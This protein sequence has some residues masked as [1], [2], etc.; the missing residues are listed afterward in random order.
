MRATWLRASSAWRRWHGSRRGR[1]A[2][3]AEAI[4]SRR[5]HRLLSRFIALDVL[6]H[7]YI[8]VRLLPDASLPP[9]VAWAGA[10]LLL[11]SCVAIPLG[12]RNRDS[13]DPEHGDFLAWAGA[14]AMGLLS[15]LFV[16]TLLRDVAF[17]TA[18]LAG[19]AGA[20]VPW[21][22]LRTASAWGVVLLALAACGA[23]FFNARRRARVVEVEVPVAGLPAA[24]EGFT[25]VQLSDIHVGPTIKRGYVQA[26]VDAVNAA[27]A[28]MVAITGDVV[29]GTVARL[30]RHTR[31][32]GDIRAPHG[33]YL[34]TGNHEYYA[35]A[36]AWVEEFC[37][38]GLRVLLNEHVVIHPGGQSVVVAGVTDFNAGT[39]DPAQRS[40]PARALAGAPADAAVRLLLAHQPRTAAAAAPLGY[41]LQLS[42]HTH[43]GQFFPWGFFVPLQ[44]PFVAG[45]HRHAGMWIYVSRGT[46][47]W[48]PP[49]R[50]AA[51]SEISRL[52]LVCA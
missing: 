33:V 4:V 34:V 29:D 46:G 8:G 12:M 5:Q 39:F 42:G 22:A 32:L 1:L 17:L 36:S 30:S 14:L 24:L 11:L 15:S 21:S 43:G 52:R 3:R 23:G 41:T 50:L 48:G 2:P 51:P 20:R 25:V 9:A 44:Q 40:S 35:G 37:R 6:A 49:K 47:Y 7:A 10:L 28:D 18:W 31:P 13:T 45:L 26:I 27:G 16:L 38:I 19:A